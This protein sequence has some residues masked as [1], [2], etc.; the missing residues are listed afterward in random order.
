MPCMHNDTHFPLHT[1]SEYFNPYFTALPIEVGTSESLFWSRVEELVPMVNMMTEDVTIYSS[2]N[3]P[4]SAI[5]DQLNTADNICWCGEPD[6]PCS[7][8]TCVP[9]IS[10]WEEFST[11]FALVS[12]GTVFW[13]SMSSTET[14][15]SS[16]FFGMYEIPNL[17]TSTVDGIV[18]L[19]VHESNPGS[20]ESCGEGTLLT[21]Q[22]RL[23]ELGF[24]NYVCYDI[25][26]DPMDPQQLADCAV[27]IITA[28]QKGV[29]LTSMALYYP[30]TQPPKN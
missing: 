10:F 22:N 3:I 20:G 14:Y 2:K 28:I 12:K 21:L 30:C 16:S 5:I 29:Y 7:C 13:L 6:E 19:V 11:R 26:G 25:Y 24:N 9:V 18:S 15:R 27:G 4:A 1:C 17:S 23:K 8:D